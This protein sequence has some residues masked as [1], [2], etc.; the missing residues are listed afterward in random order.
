MRFLLESVLIGDSDDAGINPTAK[1]LT[2]L[3]F[4]AIMPIRHQATSL[5]QQGL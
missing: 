4:R 1:P 3:R 2:T 5:D